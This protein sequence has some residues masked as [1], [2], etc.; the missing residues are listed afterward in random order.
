M[1]CRGLVVGW[2]KK[3][4][5][6]RDGKFGFG[7]GGSCLRGVPSRGRERGGVSVPCDKAKRP[8]A[9]RERGKVCPGIRCW[10]SVNRPTGTLCHSINAR[11]RNGRTDFS[12]T[13]FV[14]AGMP[15]ISLI[16]SLN[17]LGGQDHSAR[18]P[19]LDT[20]PRPDQECVAIHPVARECARSSCPFG[21]KMDDMDSVHRAT[22]CLANHAR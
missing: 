21:E 6:G 13:V 10:L 7:S 18:Q 20:L 9:P 22:D 16:H 14:L 4:T 8:A 19:N 2:C 17:S 15:V 3:Q 12:H 11:A 1:C 5:G